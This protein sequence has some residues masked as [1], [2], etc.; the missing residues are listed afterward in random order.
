MNRLP[1]DTA[2]WK[3][4]LTKDWPTRM[5]LTILTGAVALLWAKGTDTLKAMAKTEGGE[6]AIEAVK[7]SLDS[8]KGV[9]DTL[10]GQVV[11]LKGLVDTLQATQDKQGRTQQEFFGAMMN[12]IPGLKREV[13]NLGEQNLSVERKK[14][15]NETL[16]KNLTEIKP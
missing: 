10:K 3:R 1:R 11:Q 6:I 16:L 4:V 2:Y 14:A 8:L 9:V 7:P 15:E 13:Q 5:V 12:V